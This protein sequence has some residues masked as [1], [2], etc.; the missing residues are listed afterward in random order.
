MTPQCEKVLKLLRNGPTT[1]VEAEAVFQV[2]HL[3]RRIADLKELG[4]PIVRQ[5]KKDVNRQRYASYT[6]AAG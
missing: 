2:R 5:M 1:G 3:P 4:Y 6:L